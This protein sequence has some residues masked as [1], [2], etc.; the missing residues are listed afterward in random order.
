[1]SAADATPSDPARADLSRSDARRRA[2]LD[3]ASEVFLAQGYAATSMSEIAAKLGGSKGTL[4]NYF[5]SKEEL[6]SAF[7]TD[8]CQGPAMALFDQLPTADAGKSI[9]DNLVEFGAN[10]LGFIL[11]PRLIALNRIVVGETGR[12]PELGRMFFDAGPGR[13]EARFA[14]IVEA[15]MDAGELRREDPIMVGRCLKDLILSDY[16]HRQLWGVLG[17]VP[18]AQIRA[19]VASAVDA[20]LRAFAAA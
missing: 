20:F 15:A 12:F 9:R 1:M 2:I 6:F 7:I 13:G 8:T 3:V 14:Q 18:A 17:D 11:S 5:R 16:H 19:H 4:Y 10:F